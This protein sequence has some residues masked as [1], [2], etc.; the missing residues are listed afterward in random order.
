MVKGEDVVILTSAEDVDD[1]EFKTRMAL[2]GKGLWD[3]VSGTTTRPNGSDSHKPVKGYLV[4]RDTAAAE[5]VARVSRN[6]LA[7]IRELEDDPKAMWDRL[8]AMN[9]AV[10][11]ANARTLWAK[12]NDRTYR[13]PMM[14]EHIAGKR[15]LAG[16][17]KCL[18]NDELSEAQFISCIISSLPIEYDTLVESLE[19]DLEGENVEHVIGHILHKAADLEEKKKLAVTDLADPDNAAMV[20]AAHQRRRPLS[21]NPMFQVWGVWP[22]PITLYEG[23]LARKVAT[24]GSCRDC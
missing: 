3:I 22:L 19:A 7:H 24:C 14:A 1:W 21:E 10:G 4:R 15:S 2:K 18:Y 16:K 12:F 13:G 17:L 5:I 23:E 11:P 20:G 6:Q 8:I 9:R